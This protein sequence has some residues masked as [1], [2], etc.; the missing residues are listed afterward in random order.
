MVGPNKV[1]VEGPAD[2][3]ASGAS[4][5]SAGPLVDDYGASMA[6]T[7]LIAIIGETFTTMLV[8][9]CWS[10]TSTEAL[11]PSGGTSRTSRIDS[12]YRGTLTEPCSNEGTSSTSWSLA[13]ASISRYA[14]AS[15][16]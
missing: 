12:I 9:S 8:S 1:V 5:P 13:L 2:S 14:P 4:S 7:P 16:G 15:I 10:K 6:I 11:T 3:I